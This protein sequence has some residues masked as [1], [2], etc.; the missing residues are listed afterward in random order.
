[1]KPSDV[2]KRLGRRISTYRS[3]RGYT[4]EQLAEK[5]GFTSKFISEV[6]RGRVN[7]PIV[8]LAR[9]GM[10]L[11]AT[12]SELT[13][14]VDGAHANVARDGSAI[15]AGRSRHEQAAISKLL[16]ALDDVIREAKGGG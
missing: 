15:Y 7:V 13:L 14:G 3:A 11:G 4:Q 10:A 1:M 9:I 16:G 12:L 6:E 2:P 8:T 5:C